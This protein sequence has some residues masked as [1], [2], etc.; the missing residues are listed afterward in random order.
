MATDSDRPRI[1][2]GD[3]NTPRTEGVDGSVEFW[4]AEHR[5]HTERWDNAERSVLR[6]LSEHDLP[7]AYRAI[8]G[9]S[10][11]DASWVGRRGETRWGRRYDHILASRRLDVTGCRY[12]HEWREAGLSHHSDIE[13]DFAA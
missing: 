5:P 12:L 8:N 2:C 4:G 11:T 1:L 10:A 6:G 13:A 3:F 7:D 9:Y